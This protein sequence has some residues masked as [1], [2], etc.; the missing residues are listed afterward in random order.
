SKNQ[1]EKKTAAVTVQISNLK[2]KAPVKGVSACRENDVFSTSFFVLY[3]FFRYS[4]GFRCRKSAP[5][6]LALLG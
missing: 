4:S 2:Q 1:N 6:C 5:T 3:S